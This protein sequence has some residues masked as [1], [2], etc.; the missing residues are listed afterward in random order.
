LIGASAILSPQNQVIDVDLSGL[1]RR[2]L[3]FDKYIMMS[4][5]LNEFPLLAN[6]LG[7]E[8]LRDLLAAKLIEI[9]CECL[10]L[11]SMGQSGLFNI[12][13][14]PLFSYRLDWLDAADK[15]QYIHDCLRSMH[16]LGLTRKQ[17]SKLKEAIAAVIR[18]LSAQ[19]L[20]VEV[21]RALQKDLLNNPALAKTAVEMTLHRQLG[22]RDLPFSLNFYMESPEIFR[23]ECDLQER[24]EITELEAHKIIERAI[25]G[26]GGL[27]QTIAEMRYYSAISGFREDELPLFRRKLDF[28]ADLASSETKESSFQ[29]VIAIAGL[30][31]FAEGAAKIDVD[32]LLQVRD[33]NEAREFRDW[34]G[35]IGEASDR[36]IYER[37][38]GLRA[39]AGLVVGSGP[40]KVLRFLVTTGLSL[41]PHAV[42]PG[43][44]LCAADQFLV[45]KLLPKS[46]AAAFI[47]R[48]YPSIFERK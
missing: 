31:D 4:V 23:A 47:N 14:L 29:R 46:G 44:A 32:K 21:F 41:I 39:R 25:L 34:L 12:P 15:R 42:L 27:T 43:L 2:L 28:L 48:H 19:D 17:V 30:P 33:S 10:Q 6:R 45:D 9:R 3:L 38:A 7:Y 26:L 11:G 8:G 13:P 35:Q 22:R 20:R 5:R 40:A 16:G 36:E 37:V 1:V 18:P 24:A